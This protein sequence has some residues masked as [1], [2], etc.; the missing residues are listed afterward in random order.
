MSSLG[1]SEHTRVNEGFATHEM[2]YL[3]KGNRP[4]S[5][6]SGGRELPNGSPERTACQKDSPSGSDGRVTVVHTFF[7]P[8]GL[9]DSARAAASSSA[10]STA[11]VA[12]SVGRT[13]T[14]AQRAL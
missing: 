14:I 2:I 8:L 4:R 1:E 11:S 7:L 3:T 12:R 6:I 10:P 9:S 13:P 5:A